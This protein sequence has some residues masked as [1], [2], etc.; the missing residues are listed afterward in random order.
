[1]VE[2]FKTNVQEE[3]HAKLLI[4]EIHRS[5]VN[6]RATF[7]LQDCDKIL[8]VECHNDFVQTSTIINI[9]LEYGYFAEVLQESFGK[10]SDR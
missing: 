9:L 8:R 10:A 6:Y 3:Q 4:E 7:D 5:F 2:V 1:M